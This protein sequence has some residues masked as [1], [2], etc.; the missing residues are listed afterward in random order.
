MKTNETKRPT[1]FHSGDPELE[2]FRS[3]RDRREV[4]KRLASIGRRESAGRGRQVAV[5]H[6]VDGQ[7]RFRSVEFRTSPAIQNRPAA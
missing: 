5:D 1:L 3:G 7:E 4:A 2:L 6:P